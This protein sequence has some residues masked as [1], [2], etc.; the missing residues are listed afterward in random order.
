[1]D[2]KPLI[3]LSILAVVLLVLGSL[4][5]VV[6][7]QS[8]KSTVND[9]PLFQT[10]TQR[11]THQQQNSLTSQYLGM[12]KENPLHFPIRDDKIEL[13]KKVID[14]ISKIDDKT[15]AQFTELL[16]QKVRQNTTVK[17][18]NSAEIIQVF[19]LL[20]TK[21]EIIIN[22]VITRNNQEILIPTYNSY[23]FCAWSPGCLIICFIGLLIKGLIIVPLAILLQILWEL[24]EPIIV[25]LAFLL[26]CLLE[27]LKSHLTYAVCKT[28]S[29]I[30]HIL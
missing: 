27:S 25:P 7:Y 23:T 17:D 10:R 19:H 20:K 4:S 18:T 21:P 11:A 15:F 2:K 12:G 29:G 22:Y 6:G 14:M 30:L 24:L 26:Y 8:V 16:I 13:L 28:D 5:N 3:G 9:S 1:M